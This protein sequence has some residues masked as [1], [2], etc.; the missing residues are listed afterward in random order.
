MREL[1]SILI[2]ALLMGCAAEKGLRLELEKELGPDQS[3]K[4]ELESGYEF[5]NGLVASYNAETK[6]FEIDAGSATINEVDSQAAVSLINAVSIIMMKMAEMYGIVP[7]P[8][9]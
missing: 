6:S 7:V 2:I 9:E 4:L 5:D 3:T 1:I 8:D